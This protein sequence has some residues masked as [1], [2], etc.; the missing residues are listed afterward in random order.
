MLSHDSAAE[1]SVEPA[2][3]MLPLHPAGFD[4]S[5]RPTSEAPIRISFAPLMYGSKKTGKLVVQAGADQYTYQI[6]GK[7]AVAET[8]RTRLKSTF[9]TSLQDLPPAVTA[10][11]SKDNEAMREVPARKPKVSTRHAGSPGSPCYL[12]CRDVLG[13]GV[14]WPCRLARRGTLSAFLH[15]SAWR[16]CH[17]RTLWPRT[18]A[19]SR[20][21]PFSCP[22]RGVPSGRSARAS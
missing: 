6:I 3:G 22:G 20:G 12:A 14:F 19:P 7:L 21:R 10:R 18:S 1:L 17:R 15:I 8:R 2:Q 16:P 4:P 11:V 13:V 9:Q 5:L